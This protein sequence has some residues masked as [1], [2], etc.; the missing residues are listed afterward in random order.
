M[1]VIKLHDRKDLK[2]ERVSVA[3][4]STSNLIIKGNQGWN[5]SRDQEGVLLAVFSY[6][7]LTELGTT[8]PVWA[9]CMAG[10][11]DVP[12]SIIA[13]EKGTT[14]SHKGRSDGDVFSVRIPSSQTTLACVK[15]TKP[16]LSEVAMFLFYKYHIFLLNPMNK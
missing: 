11:W 13:Q 16:V 15:L 2:E 10:T 4:S 3:Y 1:T 12:G 9:L 5:R 14:G 7:L 8:S 6:C